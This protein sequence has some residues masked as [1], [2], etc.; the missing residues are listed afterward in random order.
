MT[1]LLGQHQVYI[2]IIEVPKGE[3]RRGETITDENF[4]NVKK[5]TIIQA[6]EAHRVPNMMKAK[7]PTPGNIIIKIAKVK[8]KV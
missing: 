4:P 2:C 3:E 7:R 6:L 5:E 1:G 8:Q